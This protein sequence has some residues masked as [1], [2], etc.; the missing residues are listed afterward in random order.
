MKYKYQGMSYFL[1]DL[2]Y[3]DT[4]ENTNKIKKYPLGFA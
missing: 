3:N 4:F 2:K 1:F